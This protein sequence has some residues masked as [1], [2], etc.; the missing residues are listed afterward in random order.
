MNLCF[1][2]FLEMLTE[3]CICVKCLFVLQCFTVS[4]RSLVKE[5]EFW[6]EHSW[7]PHD[8]TCVHTV[9]YRSEVPCKKYS[10]VPQAPYSPAS[11]DIFLFS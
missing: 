1:G 8:G 11:L 10:G 4:L 3:Q 9:H 5:P 7:I 2:N 6:Q